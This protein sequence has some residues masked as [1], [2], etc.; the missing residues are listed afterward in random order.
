MS[1]ICGSGLEWKACCAPLLLQGKSAA[2]AE[3]LMRSRYVAYVR[4]DGDY[5]YK[6]WASETRPSKASL[7][8]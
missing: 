5:L 7:L 3:V 8:F 1:C 2:T 4:R 6:T